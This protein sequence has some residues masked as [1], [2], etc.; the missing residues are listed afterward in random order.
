VPENSVLRKIFGYIKKEV[1]GG[2]HIKNLHNLWYPS[3]DVK[4]A[5]GDKKCIDRRT[6]EKRSLWRQK[7]RWISTAQ[8]KK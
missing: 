1:T 8:K 7:H 4:F 3:K 6:E 5:E 2:Q